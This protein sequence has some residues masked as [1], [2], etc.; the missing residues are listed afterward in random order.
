[1]AVYCGFWKRPEVW[2]EK[3]NAFPKSFCQNVR[4]EEEFRTYEFG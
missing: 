4:R 1:M 2:P 3:R